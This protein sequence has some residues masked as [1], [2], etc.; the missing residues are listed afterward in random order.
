MGGAQRTR[1][2][3]QLL[4]Q[5]PETRHS[6]S[7]DFMALKFCKQAHH[8]PRGNPSP[9]EGADG[10]AHPIQLQI[11]KAHGSLS[12]GSVRASQDSQSA[13]GN[14]ETVVAAGLN[15]SGNPK[16]ST[17]AQHAGPRPQQ[18]EAWGTSDM[19]PHNIIVFKDGAEVGRLWE[20]NQAWVGRGQVVG[21]AYLASPE[22]WALLGPQGGSWHREQ[23]S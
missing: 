20:R 1:A 22:A 7:C 18:L 23:H 13:V 3:A 8:T 16:Q 2:D 5:L 12:E 19:Q 15:A 14:P 6:S 11:L 17:S 10:V 4:L 9:K 21:S